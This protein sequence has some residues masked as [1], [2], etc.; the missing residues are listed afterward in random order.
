MGNIERYCGAT[1][2][3]QELHAT[4]PRHKLHMHKGVGCNHQDASQL[5]QVPSRH[6]W[7]RAI[8]LILH[9]YLAHCSCLFAVGFCDGLVCIQ[10][11]TS[12]RLG[13]SF[14]VQLEHIARQMQANAQTAVARTCKGTSAPMVC[15]SPARRDRM[16]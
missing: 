8:L 6:I 10:L 4:K 7:A 1:R 13:K 16:P 2:E 9:R 11:G 15:G 12:A 3:I 5:L 14:R